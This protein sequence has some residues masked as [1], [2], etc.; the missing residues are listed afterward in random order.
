MRLQEF[1]DSLRELSVKKGE[2]EYTDIEAKEGAERLVGFF[3]LLIKVD[4]R[5]KQKDYDKIKKF[6][7]NFFLC[8]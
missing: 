1:I 2:K 5:N 6:K 3:E 4:Q 7:V 8:Y